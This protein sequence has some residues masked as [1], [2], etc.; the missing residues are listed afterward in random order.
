MKAFEL[1]ICI[2]VDFKPTA[3]IANGFASDDV[4]FIVT[5]DAPSSVLPPPEME[6]PVS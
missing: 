2:N 4:Q 5:V 6:P 1:C 3:T